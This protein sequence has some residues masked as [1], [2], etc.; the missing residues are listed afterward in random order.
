MWLSHHPLACGNLISEPGAKPDLVMDSVLSI[1]PIP[2][3]SWTPSICGSNEWANGLTLVWLTHLTLLFA[4]NPG[5]RAPQ[6]WWGCTTTWGRLLPT[7]TEWGLCAWGWGPCIFPHWRQ[8]C[9]GTVSH[10]VGLQEEENFPWEQIPTFRQKTQCIPQ[11]EHLWGV[12][13][14]LF[15]NVRTR[16]FS[17]TWTLIKLLSCSAFLRSCLS[18]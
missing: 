6:P 1:P 4:V 3:T 10:P 15:S 17:V 18:P 2:G 13:I 11:R 8:W 16:L 5:S 7:P 14:L 9:S 12:F